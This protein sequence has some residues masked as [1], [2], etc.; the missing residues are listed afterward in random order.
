ML[1]S[2]PFETEC[3]GRD[4]HF[5]AVDL[6]AFG[7]VAVY[8]ARLLVVY[9]VG[10]VYVAAQRI[11]GKTVV[12]RTGVLDYRLGRQILGRN[13]HSPD[14]LLMKYMRPPSPSIASSEGE[15]PSKNVKRRSIRR[16]AGSMRYSDGAS[17]P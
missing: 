11:D 5:E 3:S 8:D 10:D 12:D 7:R 15:S 13:V 1:S 9:G 4:A 17:Q 6:D 16:V 2:W 14:V